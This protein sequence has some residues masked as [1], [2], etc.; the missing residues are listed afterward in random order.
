MEILPTERLVLRLLNP[1]NVADQELLYQ[2]DQ[3]TE[4]MRFISG[5]IPT[6]RQQHEDVLLPRLKSY[7]QIEKGWGMWG[8]FDKADSQFY[9]WILVRPMHFFST[10]PHFFDLEL[11]WRLARA[12]W[13]KG[14][15]TEAATHVMNTLHQRTG[16]NQFSAIADKDNTASI[17]IMEKLG[18]RFIKSGIHADP[19][20]DMQ[21]ETYSLAL[22]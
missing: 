1:T 10:E 22:Q 9:G 4:V 14:I 8:I 12:A 17:R 21:V 13:G 18:M 20:G 11:G 2:L 15:A 7:T 16:I 5:G 6:T 3:D 19:L